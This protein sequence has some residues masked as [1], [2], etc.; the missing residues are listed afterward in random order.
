[1]ILLI[2]KLLAT[3]YL[4]V[5]F[6]GVLCLASPTVE[7]QRRLHCRVLL[8]GFQVNQSTF[9]GAIDPN[10]WGDE[11]TL[12]THVGTVDRFRESR[13][14]IWDGTFTDVM[15][16]TPPNAVR[17]GNADRATGGLKTGNRFPT[18]NPQ[19]VTLPLRPK[20]PPA[21][22]FEG[23]LTEGWD[24]AF[25]VPTIWEWDGPDDALRRSYIA[26]IDRDSPNIIGRAY[27]LGRSVIGGL[28]DEY[29]ASG[30][31]T[32]ISNTMLLDYGRPMTR[33]IGV[34]A[35]NNRFGFIPQVVT[36]T[37]RSV[38]SFLQ[39]DLQFGRGIVPIRYTDAGLFRGDYTLLL[40]IEAVLLPDSNYK[41]DGRP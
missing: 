8:V 9:E 31:N 33:P 36:L 22:L 10:G 26:A 41:R 15:G 2:R 19:D 34:H 25:I 7:A 11:V 32:G 1:M 6:C 4:P 3:A 18:N 27:N 14:V 40:K 16:A 24:A 5:L 28:P 20:I 37:Y 17:A 12:L 35:V 21:L 38:L 23:D 39:L 29:M 13:R 30:R